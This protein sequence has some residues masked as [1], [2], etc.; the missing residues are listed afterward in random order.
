MLPGGCRST[1][2]NGKDKHASH[3]WSYG[4]NSAPLSPGHWEQGPGVPGSG[5]AWRLLRRDT[6][7]PTKRQPSASQGE[8]PSPGTKLAGSWT[9]ISAS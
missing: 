1:L 2:L 8:K 4:L 5:V 7:A 3:L 6:G 9:W